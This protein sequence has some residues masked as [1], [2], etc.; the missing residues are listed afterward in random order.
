MGAMLIYLSRQNFLGKLAAEIR[1]SLRNMRIS[2]ADKTGLL[3][4]F[5][6]V[7]LFVFAARR[8]TSDLT[9]NLISCLAICDAQELQRVPELQSPLQFTDRKTTPLLGVSALLTCI[10]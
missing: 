7:V 3:A 8:C 10:P 9:E 4:I 5:F 6:I 1:T 2:V